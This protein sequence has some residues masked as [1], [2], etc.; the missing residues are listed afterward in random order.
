[1]AID[2][3][4]VERDNV[5]WDYISKKSLYEHV[6]TIGEEYISFTRNLPDRFDGLIKYI[7][8]LDNVVFN[9]LQI[10]QLAKELS[11]LHSVNMLH[12]EVY[13]AIKCAT[14]KVVHKNNYLK[15]DVD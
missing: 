14:E 1:M 3:Y 2:I 10:A 13:T 4:L 11:Y 6:G 12:I 5:F 8:P 7:G 9:Y 15:F